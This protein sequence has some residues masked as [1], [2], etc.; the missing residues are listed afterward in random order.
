MVGLLLL[1]V[2]S[3]GINAAVGRFRLDAGVVTFL[4]LG[5]YTGLQAVSLP[6]GV[7]QFVDPLHGETWARTFRLLGHTGAAA[8][9]LEPDTTRYEAARLLSYGLTWGVVS[10]QAKRLGPLIVAQWVS[11]LVAGVAIVTVLHQLLGLR[12]VYG[13]Y[14]P[15]FTGPRWVGPLLN[16]NNLGGLCNLG[17][18]C[19][20]ACSSRRGG[21]EGKP[22]YVVVAAGLACLTFLTGSRGASI[23]LVGGIALFVIGWVKTRGRRA[24]AQH[25]ALAYAG[26][27]SLTLLALTLDQS[28]L[29]DLTGTSVEKLSL[30]GWGVDVVRNHPWVGVGMGAFGAEVSTV[31]GMSGN[32]VFPYVEC[33]PLDVLTGWGVVVGGT[34][35]VLLG[36]G[37]ARIGGGFRTY[38]LRIGL[39]VVFLQNLMDLGLQVPGLMLPTLAVFAACWGGATRRTWSLDAARWTWGAIAGTV[40][41]GGLLV[42]PIKSTVGMVRAEVAA[43]LHSP[44]LGAFLKGALLRHPGD[45]YLL[46]TQ[47]AVAVQERSAHAVAWVNSALL[48]APA[49]ARTHLLLAQLLF[50]RG[51][52]EQALPAL[53]RAAEDP[54]LHR[55]VIRLVGLEARD[56]LLDVAPNNPVGASLL[57]LVA[58]NVTDERRVGLLQA[59]ARRAPDSAEIAVELTGAKLRHWAAHTAACPADSACTAELKALISRAESLGAKPNRIRVLRAQMQALEGDNL[60]AFEALLSGC[61]RSLQDRLCLEVLLGVSAKLGA[62]EYEQASRAFLDAVCAGTKGCSAERMGVAHR[63]ARL[64]R[65]AAAHQLYVQECA[66][67]GNVDAFVQAAHTA[68]QLGRER[69]AWHWLLKGEQKYA[70][71][72]VA[73]ERLGAARRQLGTSIR[74][75]SPGE[76]D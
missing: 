46:R 47:A 63:L 50:S 24:G 60:G 68:A 26:V 73:L 21:G 1:A 13:V 17:V 4:A 8:L 45:A 33:L 3:A 51:Q 14:S 59:A 61:E 75:T 48:R 10:G 20:L 65:V 15:R 71:D 67:S 40:I 70:G 41:L 19:S 76:A 30:L 74:D 53:R 11:W 36:L 5:L 72:R 35:L 18:F 43:Q 25:W 22:A 32:V 44:N 38:T 57:R 2:S 62:V 16:P 28:T 49:D 27:A 66:Q 58:G 6:L 12:D 42:W 29:Q 69:E 55:E 37:F 34:A 31:S 52:V 39:A 9:S 23:A 54:L 64:G 7:V 56:R